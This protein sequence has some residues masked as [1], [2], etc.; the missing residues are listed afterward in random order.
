LGSLSAR[1]DDK[2]SSSPDSDV[3]LNPVVR[4][5]ESDALCHP[6]ARS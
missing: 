3:I 4:D 6:E 5:E 1:G 2:V